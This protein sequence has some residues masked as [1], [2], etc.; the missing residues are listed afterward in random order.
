MRIGTWITVPH[1]TIVDLIS[2]QDFD[3]VC[4]DL[5]HSP[6]SR[7]ELQNSIQIIQGNGKKAF[8][9]VPKNDHTEVKFP[10]DAGVDGIILP[11]VNSA[12]ETSLALEN[13]LYPPLGKRGV[14]LSRAQGYGF[15]FEDHLRQNLEALEIIVQVEH[16]QAVNEIDSILDFTRL[17]GVFLG[18]YDLSGSL[19]LPGQLNHPKVQE[20]IERVADKTLSR[21]KILGAHVIKPSAEELDRF[22]FRGYNFLAFS[23]DT[24]FM[25]QKIKDEMLAVRKCL[26]GPA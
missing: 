5:E 11:M 10:L 12:E 7:S 24:F 25:G 18:P 1:P 26:G 3:W 2:Q 23:I 21:S 13:C 9:R 17:D 16:I 4:V 19:G 14:G 8:V 22:R 6:V 20:A 15:K